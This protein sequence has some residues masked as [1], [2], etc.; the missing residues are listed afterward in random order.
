VL[1]VR[2]TQCR[3]K[4]YIPFRIEKF[5]PILLALFISQCSFPVKSELKTAPGKITHKEIYTSGLSNSKRYHVLVKYSYE[6]GGKKFESSRI[7]YMRFF[8]NTQESAEKSI[9]S[10]KL[11]APVTVYYSPTDPE[12]SYLEVDD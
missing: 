12:D 11:D 3:L 9:D 6:V 1:F 7:G 4:W 5:L 2:E 8:Y 10:Y